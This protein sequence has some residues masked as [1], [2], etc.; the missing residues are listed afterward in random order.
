MK[1]DGGVIG[2]NDM[3]PA[4]LSV[5]EYDL[6]H[7]NG[8]VPGE[9]LGLSMRRQLSCSITNWLVGN[10]LWQSVLR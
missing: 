2:H 8:M 3:A 10:L 6:V 1:G 9:D 7:V 5:T 4:A